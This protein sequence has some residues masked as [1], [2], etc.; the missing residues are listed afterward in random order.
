MNRQ[1]PQRAFSHQLEELSDRFFRNHL[2]KSWTCEKPT[3]DYG[4]DLKVDLYD[5]Q[6]ATGLEL[7]VQL[8][9]SKSG[10]NKETETIRLRTATYNYLSD[11][12]QVVMLVKYIEKEDEAYWLFLSDTPDP[13]QSQDTFTVHIPK[14][15]VLSSIDW[16]SIYDHIRGVTDKKLAASR[17][18]RIECRECQ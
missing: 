15:N 9:T 2:P 5:D 18:Y 12:L 11:K 1:Y 16:N 13:D 14:S 3:P 4:V 8:K 7:L 6:R 17:K 10:S